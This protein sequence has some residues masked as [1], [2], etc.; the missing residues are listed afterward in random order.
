MRPK[1][2]AKES[3]YLFPGADG[4]HIS[5]GSVQQFIRRLAQ[6]AGLHGIKCSPHIFRH[7]FATQAIAVEANV[8]TLKDIMGHTSL[9]TAL[10]YTHLKAGD[11]KNQH[12]KF[13]PV[14]SLF[15]GK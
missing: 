7:T 15:E 6:K 4:D 11:L 1:L 12:N 14:A 8:F 2:Y 10:Q 13:S 9:Q 5:V 3:P